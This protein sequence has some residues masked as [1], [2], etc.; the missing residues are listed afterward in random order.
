MK[1]TALFLLCLLL[2]VSRAHAAGVAVVGWRGDTGNSGTPIRFF[3]N[4]AAGSENRTQ[5][6]MPSAGKFCHLEVHCGSIT[7]TQTFTLRINGVSTSLEAAITNGTHGSDH[8]TGH[9]ATFAAEDLVSMRSVS[10][11]GGTVASCKITAQVLNTDDSP[12]NGL[13]WFGDNNALTPSNGNYCGPSAESSAQ[14]CGADPVTGV[15]LATLIAPSSQSVV[16]LGVHTDTAITTNPEIYTIR[17]VTNACDYD[18]AVSV[19]VGALK[20]SNTCVPGNAAGGGICESGGLTICTVAAGER[21]TVK[22]NKASAFQNIRRSFV[23]EVTG[24]TWWGTNNHSASAT[25]YWSPYRGTGTTTKANESWPMPVAVNFQNLRVRRATACVV[26]TLTVTACGDDASSTPDCTS[27]PS[28]TIATNTTTT[29]VAGPLTIAQGGWL[30]TEITGCAAIQTD[31]QAWGEFVDTTPADTPTPLNT[32][33]P[34][35]TPTNTPT[36]TLTNTPTDTPTHTP[37]ATP[38]RTPTNT[39]TRTPTDTPDPA[40]PTPTP[41]R[42]FTP[43]PTRTPTPSFTPPTFCSEIGPTMVVPSITPTPSNTPTP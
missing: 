7:G 30:T 5:F 25:A 28:N 20:E 15:D 19:S 34:T 32:S 17:N 36:S 35:S 26:Q 2:L 6:T 14:S 42:T 21:I 39:P 9:C 3:I 41:T 10:S 43:T 16:G 24:G 38:T 12:H 8:N 13:M 27:D 4:A 33:T 1:R 40:A 22:A 11:G 29:T 37:T 31:T 18:G 23:L